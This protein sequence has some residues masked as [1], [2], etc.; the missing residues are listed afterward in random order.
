[1]FIAKY[2]IQIVMYS[3]F[4]ANVPKQVVDSNVSH[5]AVDLHDQP[6]ERS[7]TG[8]LLGNEINVLF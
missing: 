6:K 8:M 7:Q 3:N 5:K 4:Y 1:M 2:Q